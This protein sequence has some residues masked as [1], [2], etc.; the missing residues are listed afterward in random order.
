MTIGI[1]IT[2]ISGRAFL[3]RGVAD[4]CLTALEKHGVVIYRGADIEDAEL[5]EFSR[6]LGNVVVAPRGNLPDHPEIAPVTLDPTRNELAAYLHSTFFWHIDGAQD[7]VPQKGTLLAAREVA[8]EGGDTEFANTYVAY[9]ALPEDEKA[10]IADLRVVHSI[11]AS[12]LLMYPNP[13]E[14]LR[15]AWDSVPTREHPLVWTR[16]NGR[17]SLLIGASA[18]E[19]VGMS[20]EDG[21][22]LLDH[23]LDWCTQPQFVRHHHWQVGDL[24]VWDNTGMLHRAER[25][26]STSRRL[27]HRTTLAGE[28][29]VA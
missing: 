2:G 21:R 25:Y 3:D 7:L 9:D 20:P 26:E 23:L 19:V 13:S 8:E 15:K 17:K 10:A 4:E 6:M 12:Q 22:A 14:K 1:E 28:Q 24:V 18:G 27:L 11:A 29:A 5:V 16:P